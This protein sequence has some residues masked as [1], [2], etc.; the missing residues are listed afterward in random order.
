MPSYIDSPGI[1]GAEGFAE[2]RTLQ[3]TSG[4]KF[5]GAMHY[6]GPQDSL[7]PPGEPN[8]S[9]LKKKVN[10]PGPH[11]QNGK[12]ILKKINHFFDNT[13]INKL[14]KNDFRKLN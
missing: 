6:Q 10:G 7:R 1:P 5:Q 12:I 8:R 13:K 4:K 11:Q 3:E 9:P 14:Y 2:P